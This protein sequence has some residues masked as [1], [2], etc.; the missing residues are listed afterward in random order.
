MFL[1]QGRGMVFIVQTAI[2]LLV[3]FLSINLIT[4]L[5]TSGKDAMTNNHIGIAENSRRLH[6]KE[7]LL[8]YRSMHNPLRQRIEEERGYLRLRE[9]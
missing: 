4:G 7:E 2:H 6:H 5:T 8:P 1:R 9:V 3:L